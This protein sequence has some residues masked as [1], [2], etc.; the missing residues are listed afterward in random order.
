MRKN[1]ANKCGN[2]MRGGDKPAQFP[3]KS[4]TSPPGS[5]VPRSKV[6][7]DRDVPFN[8]VKVGDNTVES[9]SQARFDNIFG[10]PFVSQSGGDCGCTGGGKRKRRKS[11][12]KSRRKTKRKTTTKRKPKKKTTRRK[13]KRSTTLLTIAKKAV[14]TAKK[15]VKKVVKVEKSI[16]KRVKQV[17]R[18]LAKLKRQ[19]L[20]ANKSVKRAKKKVKTASKRVKKHSR[21]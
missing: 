11:K 15:D 7:Y 2:R 19:A 10:K 18:R 13:T 5:N 17:E 1:R 6:V 12:R 16:V 9:I 21:K 8:V 20:S 4:A 14:T 3:F